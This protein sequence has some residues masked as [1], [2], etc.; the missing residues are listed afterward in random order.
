MS[1]QC[2]TYTES[3]QPGLKLQSLSGREFFDYIHGQERQDDISFSGA[4]EGGERAR[5]WWRE[6]EGEGEREREREREIA[7]E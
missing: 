6:I 1:I 4:G 2:T 7:R 3:H 5:G